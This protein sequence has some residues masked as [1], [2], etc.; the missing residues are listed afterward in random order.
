MIVPTGPGA[1]TDVIARLMADSIS[2]SL[3]QPVV[4]ENQPGASG[5]IAHQSASRAPRPT[6][7]RSCS[8][9]PRGS[10]PTS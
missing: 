4:V 6:A 10:R 9:T 1:A 5:L 7:T 3:G 8:P 2:R